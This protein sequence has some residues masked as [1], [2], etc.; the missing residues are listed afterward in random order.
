MRPARP[1]G[2]RVPR[3]FVGAGALFLALSL[4]LAACGGTAGTGD[5]ATGTPQL[6]VSSAQ[7]S[8]PV[9]GTSQLVLEIRNTGDGPDRLISASTDVALAVELHLT[10]IE[11]SGRA[12]MRKLD[13][14]ALPP[15]E[16]VRF[17]PGGLHLM[18]VVPDPT[19]VV[20]STF[21]VTLTF[22]RSEDVTVPVTVVALLDLVEQTQAQP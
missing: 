19:L 1:F 2:S 6:E 18:V 12:L 22:E 7:A 15:G 14:V 17:R 21:D 5:A 16:V 9:A 4:T 8:A 10:E 3:R 20:G 11:P 13:A